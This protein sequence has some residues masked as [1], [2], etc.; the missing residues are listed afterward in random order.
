MTC[1]FLSYFKTLRKIH[2]LLCY[3]WYLGC[4][5]AFPISRPNVSTKFTS[6][7]KWV[8]IT[9]VQCGVKEGGGGTGETIHSY[10]IEATHAHLVVSNS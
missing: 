3:A 10:T 6:K 7:T 4:Q 2:K 8:F 5:L 1:S 9:F